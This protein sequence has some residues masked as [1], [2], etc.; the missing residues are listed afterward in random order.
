MVPSSSGWAY[1]RV[2]SGSTWTGSGGGTTGM[3]DSG[4]SGGIVIVDSSRQV[5]AAGLECFDAPLAEPFR[6]RYRGRL[7]HGP[8]AARALGPLGAGHGNVE[9]GS[10]CRGRLQCDLRHD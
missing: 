5:G 8:P 4:V 10:V 9:L 2:D 6:L 3:A 7:C 1:L